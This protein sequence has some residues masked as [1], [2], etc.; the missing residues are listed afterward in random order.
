MADGSV[1]GFLEN[2]F[3]ADFQDGGEFLS[4][5]GAA[6]TFDLVGQGYRAGQPGESWPSMFRY[7][8]NL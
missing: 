7:L 2:E 3:A 5:E 8:K 4:S 6:N 1:F